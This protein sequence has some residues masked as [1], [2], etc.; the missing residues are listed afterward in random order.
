M[1]CYLCA[2]GRTEVPQ[3]SHPLP[4]GTDLGT[5]S[6]C[7]VWACAAHGT[8]YGMFE[9]A[10]CTSATAVDD[11]LSASSTGG[12]APTIAYLTGQFASTDIRGRVSEALNMVLASS[13]DIQ[14]T[15]ERRSFI[16]PGAGQINV[17]WNLADYVRQNHPGAERTLG[18]RLESDRPNIRGGSLDVIAGAVRSRFAGRELALSP[19][20]DANTVATG[21]ML[22]GYALA[23]DEL[24]QRRQDDPVGWPARVTT[25]PAPW[26]V[27]Y[28][29]LLDPTL[30]LVG[31]ALAR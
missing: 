21:A 5:C 19:D 1:S 15:T 11:A 27:R 24:D 31:A 8:R 20:E 13:R 28:P 3:E 26:Q 18:S 10:I 6:K 23:D 22:L 9:C 4:P 29:I 30:W 12:P 7:S 25:L 14:P 17:V 2:Y 16:A